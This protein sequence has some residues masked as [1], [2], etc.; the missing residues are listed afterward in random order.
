MSS[1]HKV[2]QQLHYMYLGVGQNYRVLLLLYIVKTNA[3]EYYTYIW[4]ISIWYC[5]CNN[6]PIVHLPHPP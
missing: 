1:V 6:I 3:D 2:L 4:L 5:R